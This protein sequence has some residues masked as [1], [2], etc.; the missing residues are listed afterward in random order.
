MNII[1]HVQEEIKAKRTSIFFCSNITEKLSLSYQFQQSFC[2][3]RCTK[4]KFCVSR[5]LQNVL[6]CSSK[7]HSKE[8]EK[9]NL[10]KKCQRYRQVM[11]LAMK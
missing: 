10:K 8:N 1:F 7:I 2:T 3:F 6:D 11:V 4:I 5:K 9:Q